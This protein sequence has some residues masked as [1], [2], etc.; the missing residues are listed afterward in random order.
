MRSLWT[1]LSLGSCVMALTVVESAA[2]VYPA[3]PAQAA[4]APAGPV[5][6]NDLQL[7]DAQLQAI[8]RQYGTTIPSGSYWY[9]KM[10]GA[11]GMK[12]G[13][14]AGFILP[15]LDLGGPLKA[16]ASNGNTGVF[17]NGRQL[18][19]QDVMALQQI[20][21]VYPGRYWMDSY[22][23]VGYEGGPAVVNLLALM[24]ARGGAG[25]DR[26]MTTYTRSGAMFGSDGN[27]CLVFNDPGSHTSYTGSGC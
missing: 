18:H 27:G 24:K 2:Q 14:T 4:A 9:D 10:T 1:A 22:G 7:A 19:M 11:W 25:G 8:A 3:V 13:P 6:I 21:P 16:D 15:G 26:S 5:I 17:V 12:G 23:N 20:T